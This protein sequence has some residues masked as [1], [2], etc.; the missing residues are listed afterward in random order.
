MRVVERLI[1][2]KSSG[3]I[4]LV[5]GY[6]DS[7]HLG[8]CSLISECVNSG[9]I[10]AIFTFRNS[11]EVC[12]N[13][14]NKQCFTYSE[15]LEIFEKL[16]VKLV[17]SSKF[18]NE[19]MMMEGYDFLQT[20]TQNNNIKL[21]VIGSDFCC[22]KGALYKA[23]DIVNYFN[24]KGIKIIV[25]DLIKANGLKIASRKIK[26]MLAAGEI[27]E[28][29]NLLPYPFSVSGKVLRGRNVGGKVLGYPTAN[30]EYPLDKVQ[31]KA[32]VYK[33]NIIVNN[34][35]YL[36]LTNVGAHP[37]FDDYN[38]N[39]ESFIIGYDGDIYESC[40]TVEF[41]A[42]LREIKKFENATSLKKQIDIDFNRV[43][44]EINNI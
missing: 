28:V 31:I 13:G 3:E 30:I 22:G 15:R 41:I 23:V 25:K 29:N 40:I 42:Y 39:I 20:L 16:Q 1:N 6:F 18:D 8:H 27:T 44:S 32:G 24:N 21:I 37:T 19:F 38:Y 2:Q 11:P 33:T 43:T 36:A 34:V 7:V 10:P 5:L 14:D 9:L 35:K 26:N 17:I 12:F 4:A